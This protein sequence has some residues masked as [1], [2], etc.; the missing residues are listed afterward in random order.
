MC[1]INIKNK[2]FEM[3]EKDFQKFNSKLIPSIDS[4]TVIGVKTLY[5]RKIAKELYRSGEYTEYLLDIPHKYFEENQIHAFVIAEIN[6]FDTCVK[7]IE[8]F[9]PY[10]DNWA[11]CD[12][13]SP[14][15]FRKHTKE[16]MEYIKK[17]ISSSHTYTIRFAVN[18]LMRYYLDKDYEVLYSNMVAEIE[19]EDYYV[20]MARAWYFATALAKHK[21]IILPYIENKVLDIWTHNKTIQKA[22][23][24][25]RIEPRL[26]EYLK[27]LKIK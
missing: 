14:K 22:V 23:E 4:K 18:M 5:L 17:W 19:H 9:L 27:T 16:L 3:S 7:E 21:E 24:S 20:N 13:L 2:L 12:Q 6:D 15:V 11:T 10:I 26:K 8:H 25:F 1:Y